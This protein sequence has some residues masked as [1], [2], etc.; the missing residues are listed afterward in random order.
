LGAV[1][2][3]ATAELKT[4]ETADLRLLYFH[5]TQAFLAPH[6]ARCFENSIQR[7]K[8]VFDYEPS[9]QVTTLMTDFSDYGNAAANALP[10][11]SLFVDIAPLPFTFETAAP[12]ERLFTIMNHELVHVATTDQAAPADLR[13]RKFFQGKVAANSSHPLTILYQFLTVPRKTSPRWYLEG[14]ATFMETWMAGGLGRAQ[15]AY[16]E[17]VFR[18]MVRDDA[19]FYD[20]LGLVAEGTK[21]DFQ[22][23]ANAYLY[24]TRFMSYM[25]LKYSPEKLVAWVQRLEGSRRHYSAQFRH[26]YGMDLDDAWQEWI[27]WEHEFQE[28]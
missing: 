18:S 20:P 25:A 9:S 4:L 23:G 15:G 3:V 1:P 6:A 13:Y 24:G 17:M 11:N 8:S 27:E 16:D 19:H 22:V 2:A 12:A 14:I 21:V 7:Q 28:K 10:R 5:P 26:V